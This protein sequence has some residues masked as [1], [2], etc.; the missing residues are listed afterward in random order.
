MTMV[1]QP[2]LQLIFG[3]CLVYLMAGYYSSYALWTV[4]VWLCYRIIRRWL[5][6]P[7]LL[8]GRAVVVTGASTGFGKAIALELAARGAVVFAGSRREEDGKKLEEAY[9]MLKV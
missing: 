4:F 7:R 5:R 2:D 9:S 1:I 3:T 6:D 8:V